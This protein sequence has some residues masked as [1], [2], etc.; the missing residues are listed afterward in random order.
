MI[1]DK[2]NYI[3]FSVHVHSNPEIL[4]STVSNALAELTR[5]RKSNCVDRIPC[6]KTIS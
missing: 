1:E 2:F 3:L 6:D 5:R 4:K